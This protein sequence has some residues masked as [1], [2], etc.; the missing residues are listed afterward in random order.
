MGYPDTLTPEV[1]DLIAELADLRE[2]VAL[3]DRSVT[4]RAAEAFG[5]WPPAQEMLP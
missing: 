2:D 5:E 3:R 4:I 1:K